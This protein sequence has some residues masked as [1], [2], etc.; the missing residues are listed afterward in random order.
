MLITCPWCGPRDENEFHY[1]GAAHRAYPTD[2]H[3]LSDAEWAAYVFERPNPKGRFEERWSH[4]AGCRRWFNVV[5]DTVTHEI[6]DVDD[7]SAPRPVI[8]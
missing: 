4:S 3:A 2:P 1:G 5:R 8:A 7:T 6:L